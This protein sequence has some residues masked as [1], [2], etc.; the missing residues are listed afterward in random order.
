MKHADLPVLQA[1]VRDYLQ[2]GAVITLSPD[3]VKRTKYW[4][5]IFPRAKKDSPKQRLITDLRLLNQCAQAKPHKAQSWV[6]IMEVLRD[7]EL[8][9]ALRI[10]LKSWFHHL[11]V[12]QNTKRWMRFRLGDHAYQVES[13]PFGWS[14]SP[15][16]ANKMAKPLQGWLH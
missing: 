13:M 2:E 4:V 14:M 16:F 3:L 1:C 5:P 11:G 6:H 8:S 7:Q 15:W 10:D 9:W 12:H